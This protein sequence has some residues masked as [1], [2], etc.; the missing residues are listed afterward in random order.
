[1][2]KRINGL[3]LV[4]D[5][6]TLGIVVYH[7]QLSAIQQGYTGFLLRIG[8]WGNFCTTIFFVLSGFLLYYQYNEKIHSIR[9]VLMFYKKE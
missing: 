3:Y 9:D 2:Q 7:F 4:R 6:A 1:M 8:A 5:I